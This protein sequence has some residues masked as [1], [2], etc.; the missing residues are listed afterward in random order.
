ME[1]HRGLQVVVVQKES[2]ERNIEF[3]NSYLVE[4]LHPQLCLVAG[5]EQEAGHERGLANGVVHGLELA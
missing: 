2:V 4:M 1:A 3:L 5:G